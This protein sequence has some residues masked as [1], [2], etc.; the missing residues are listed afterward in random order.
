MTLLEPL[1]TSDYYK[2]E[3]D[4]RN[5]LLRT[6]WLRSVTEDEFMAGGTKLK[7]LVEAHNITKVLANAQQL[8][9][10]TPKTKDW[11]SNAFY[12]ELSQL[13]ISKLARVMPPDLFSRIALESVI[14][15]AEAIGHINF[16]VKNFPDDQEALDWLRA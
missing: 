4:F 2:V 13:N 7:Q 8:R 16:L 14:T 3:V 15:R 12:E 11:L 9:T 1:Y 5:S 6:E 10:I